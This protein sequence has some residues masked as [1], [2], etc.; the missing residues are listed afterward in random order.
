MKIN[1]FITIEEKEEIISFVNS[2]NYK[3]KFTNEHIKE[4]ADKLCGASYMFDITKTN[5]SS[6]LSNFQSSNN[7][8]DHKLTD[9]FYIIMNRISDKLYIP[10]DNVF[11]Q[12]LDMD[13]GGIITP[14]YDTSIDGYINYK[15][16]IS[17]LSEDY[18]LNVDKDVIDVSERDLYS[19]EASLYKHWT[20]NK[21]TE[22]R[23]LLSYG[24]G[25]TYEQLGRN[26]NDPRV[27]LSKR[28]NK[29]FQL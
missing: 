20:E 14:H 6:Y 4:V 7:I 17:V 25:L 23:I 8:C 26:D 24:F 13:R 16:N 19:F 29:Y 18:T 27:R 2:I 3:P 15:C 21:F 22:R 28:I 5:V 12:I 11:L 1:E 9:I 10:T